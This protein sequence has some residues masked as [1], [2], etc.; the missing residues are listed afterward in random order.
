MANKNIQITQE[1]QA[2]L[3]ELRNRFKVELEQSGACVKR[4]VI[5]F[6]DIDVVAEKPTGFAAFYFSL[7]NETDEPQTMYERMEDYEETVEYFDT[8]GNRLSYE[9]EKRSETEYVFRI[10]LAQEVPPGERMELFA[11][12]IPGE[13]W[14]TVQRNRRIIQRNGPAIL[15]IDSGVGLGSL[16]IRSFK[17]PS[18]CKLYECFEQPKEIWAEG[19]RLNLLYVFFGW[20]AGVEWH[21][22]YVKYLIP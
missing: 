18:G 19:D 17:M 7:P 22:I 10:K 14:L 8:N 21:K 11:K 1:E 9:M 12:A 6:Y 5:M 4:E 20:H 13:K 3:I 16:F 2:H 15:D